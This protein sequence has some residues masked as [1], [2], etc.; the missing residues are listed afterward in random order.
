MGFI[1]WLAH[2]ASAGSRGALPHTFASDS[3]IEMAG[4]LFIVSAAS[5]AGKTTLVK[6]LLE[7]DP[8]VQL[9]VSYTT[10]PPRPGE[11]HGRDYHFVPMDNFLAMR[12]RGEFVENAE[13]HGNYYG[14]SKVWLE[15][16]IEAGHDVL[17]EIDWQGARQ[18]RTV[19]PRAIAVFI[20]PPSLQELERR[21]RGRGQDSDEVVLR[22][23]AA[24]EDEMRHVPEFDYVILNRDL[25]AARDDLAAVVRTSRLRFESQRARHTECFAFLEQ[26]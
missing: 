18:V 9:S 1:H 12:G 24:A 10:R 5:G 23:L 22:R 19:F 17:L 2:H 4:T 6:M 26:D 15:E 3:Q 14:T 11:V 13:V 8:A 16:R 20:M 21:L 25:A 7:I